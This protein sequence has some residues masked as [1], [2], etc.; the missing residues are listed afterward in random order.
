MGPLLNG[1]N[2]I[3]P[4]ISSINPAMDGEGAGAYPDLSPPDGRHCRKRGQKAGPDT[5]QLGRAGLADAAERKLQF[6][7]QDRRRYFDIIVELTNRLREVRIVVNSIAPVDSS[8]GGGPGRSLLN[9]AFL[10]PVVT[11][12]QADIGNLGLKVLVSNTGGH[13]FGPDNDLTGQ[14]N[15]C[16]PDANAFNRL[17]FDPPQAEHHDED[18]G[19]K[20]QVN[21]PGLAVRTNAANYNEPPGN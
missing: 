6:T 11:E 8:L 20:V 7:E 9:K 2:Q 1:L 4:H 12:K 13:I 15:Q 3:K 18:H 17:S 16:L 5:A 19:L 10:E 14:I 21:R